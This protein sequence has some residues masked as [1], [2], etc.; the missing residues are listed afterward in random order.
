MYVKPSTKVLN[1][2][3]LF[4]ELKKNW[5]PGIKIDTVDSDCPSDS[6]KSPIVV[7][8]PSPKIQ[9]NKKLKKRVPAKKISATDSTGSTESGNLKE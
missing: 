3:Y 4:S 1:H 2:T 7:D 9:K 5:N 8:S 6:D